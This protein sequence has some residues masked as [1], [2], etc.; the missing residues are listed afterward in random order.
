MLF[1]K[2]L[3]AAVLFVCLSQLLRAA[4]VDSLS[5]TDDG[6]SVTITHCS[7]TASGVLE[8]P[9]L[10]GGKP[11]TAIGDYAFSRCNY[12]TRVTIPAGVTRLGDQSFYQCYRLTAMSIPASVTS[13]GSEAF[14]YCDGLTSL[15]LAHGLTRIG[16]SAFKWC[17]GLGNVTIP[18]S[19]T[20]IDNDA[21][22]T[23]SALKK[24]TFIGHAPSMGTGVF[25]ETP[26]AFKVYFLDGKKGFTAPT[27]RGY[28][29]VRLSAEIAI[30]QPT[31]SELVSGVAARSFG[32]VT[33]GKMGT[34]KKFTVKNTGKIPLTGL[35][36]TIGGVHA[37][38][39]IITSPLVAT[40]AP[41]ASA[42][43]K[44]A[45]KPKA[46]G[47]R[48]ATLSIQSNDRDEN[49]FIIGLGGAGK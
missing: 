13:I 39:F 4:T 42:T 28:P 30:E 31:R 35:V 2:L 23:C 5:Y 40:L 26:A 49:P 43:F 6:I 7:Q 9:P 1:E 33:S 20:R 19:V 46:K 14:F 44:V 29:A 3:P 11:V 16:D 48:P 10:L 17:T 25:N 32:T 24:A 38:D 47:S 8:I 12:L 36:I 22:L 18:A 41:G 15:T 27:W 21:F 37:K 34:P 45:F